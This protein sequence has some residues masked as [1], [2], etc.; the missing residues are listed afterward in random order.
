MESSIN[1]PN[2]NYHLDNGNCTQIQFI[3]PVDFEEKVENL[4][5]GYAKYFKTV[6]G[7]LNL[8]KYSTRT[9]GVGRNGY[10]YRSMVELI[11]FAYSLGI[12]SVRDIAEHCEHDI[13][14]MYISGD[15]T[16]SFMTIAR[17]IKEELS[18]SV[19]DIFRDVNEYI[20]THDTIDEDTIYI[21]GTKMQA[22]A[23]KFS[24]VW[25]KAVLGY[26]AKLMDKVTK[27]ILDL[28][29]FYKE[30]NIDIL[31][32]TKDKYTS[33][34]I[35]EIFK[36]L[37]IIR[38]GSDTIFAHGI[39]HRK[40]EFQRFYERFEELLNKAKEYEEHLKICGDRNSYSKTDHD[41][42]FMHSKEDYYMKTGIFRAMYNIQMGI[43]DE[44][45]RFVDVS[46][47]Q[48]DT[49]TFKRFIEGFNDMYGYYPK[50]PVADAG[51]GSFAN[52]KYCLE[53]NME[54]VQKYPMYAK[55]HDNKYLKNEFISFNYKK[56]EDGDYLCPAG[57]KFVFVEEKISKVE[58]YTKTTKYFEVNKC[59]DCP[60]RSKCHSNNK[61]DIKKKTLQVCDEWNEMK[62]TV[63]ANLESELG[64]QQRVRRSIEAEGT[65]GVLKFD[66]E[67]D[68]I[69]RRGIDNV[70]TELLL[71]STGFNL[72]KLYRRTIE[73]S[74]QA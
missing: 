64:I 63:C 70:R 74:A 47:D 12:I 60:L 25:K 50:Y 24:F 19:K 62:K 34:D 20:E 3:F 6:M 69:H 43:S 1:E 26:Q 52:Y 44:Y 13:R 29:K 38:C 17:F 54:L 57:H 31:L 14:F 10:D 5:S 23:T 40:Q 73:R 41:A 66:W 67:Y 39:G 16:P 56:D 9:Y 55:E 37:D 36:N 49:K 58:G 35:Q 42:T 33:N 51:Y 22:N 2:Y 32:L 71:V 11:L 65:F 21:D 45:I 72:R 46:Q 8:E 7:G 30:C 53:H 59:E 15:I 18:V 28:D 27:T 48:T 4:T 61:H 68:R